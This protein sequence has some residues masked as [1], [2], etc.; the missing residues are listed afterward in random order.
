[1]KT[2]DMVAL[3]SD[4][5]AEEIRFLTYQDSD[6]YVV[7]RTSSDGPLVHVSVSAGRQ[8]EGRLEEGTQ[9]WLYERKFRRQRASQDFRRTFL[10]SEVEPQSIETLVQDIFG[11]GFNRAAPTPKLIC[12]PTITTDNQAVIE[13]MTHLAKARDWAARKTLYRLLIDAWFVVALDESGEFLLEDRMGTW[14]VCAVCL[15][16]SAFI[17]RYPTGH[18]YRLAQG[19]DLFPELVDAKYGS[20]RINPKS[21]VRGELYFNELKMIGDGI[22]RLNAHQNR[23][24]AQEK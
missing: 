16:Q 10:R 17:Q 1:M 19:R 21:E 22:V 2:A 6:Y 9:Q 18:Y 3:C 7:A 8:V 14:P 15:D 20:L 13:A 12:V 23:L 24:R 4:F 11:E 5:D